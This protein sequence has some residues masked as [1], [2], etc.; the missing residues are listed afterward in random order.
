MIRLKK[1]YDKI[2]SLNMINKLSQCQGQE[3]F[4]ESVE[5]H[6]VLFQPKPH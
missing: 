6:S 5:N 1:M 4:V 2:F 3:G